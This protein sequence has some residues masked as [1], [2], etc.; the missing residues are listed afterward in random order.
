MNERQIGWNGKTGG[1]MSLWQ[2]LVAYAAGA[3]VLVVML[4]MSAV[5]FAVAIT[6]ALII[7][8]RFWWK[9]RELRKRMREAPTDDPFAAF[10]HATEPGRVI[11]G[12]V[13]QRDEPRP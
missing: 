11:E 4:M 7:W 9:T 5:L 6:A 10:R 2:K 3:V 8:A 1:P 13:V 12:E